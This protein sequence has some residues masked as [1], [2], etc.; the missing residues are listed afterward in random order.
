MLS[1]LY[2]YSRSYPH[3]YHCAHANS[4]SLSHSLSYFCLYLYSYST[5]I[6]ILTLMMLLLLLSFVL[7]FILLLLHA[8][9]TFALSLAL[10]VTVLFSP[11][12]PYM[13]HRT[14]YSDSYPRSRS[15]FLLLSLPLLLPLLVLC[16]LA[17]TAI[18]LTCTL[19]HTFILTLTLFL[20]IT[21]T[22]YPYSHSHPDSYHLCYFCCGACSRTSLKHVRAPDIQSLKAVHW[23]VPAVHRL[24]CQSLWPPRDCGPSDPMPTQRCRS[25]AS[26]WTR[27]ATW[28]TGPN[29]KSRSGT[30]CWN[31]SVRVHTASCAPRRT[32]TQKTT[33]RSRR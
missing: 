19:A 20:S 9:L 28:S 18:T 5:C 8:T 21:L 25:A 2:F 14:S 7:L 23:R 3:P 30:R 24:D 16:I 11:H 29:S 1:L 33:Q 26:S 12:T 17:L 32:R 27:V 31:L 4:R 6:R 22:C 15:L 10:T 13:V